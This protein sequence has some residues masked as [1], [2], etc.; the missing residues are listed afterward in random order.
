MLTYEELS[1]RIKNLNTEVITRKITIKELDDL[2]K[3][4]KKNDHISAQVHILAALG[5]VNY[6]HAETKKAFDFLFDKNP[7]QF[8]RGVCSVRTV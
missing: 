8:G 4:A 5:Q 2:L 7:V 6:Y 1:E 3:S